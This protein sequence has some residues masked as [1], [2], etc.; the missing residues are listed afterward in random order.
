M[1]IEELRRIIENSDFEVFGLRAD[2]Y[3]YSIGDDAHVSH[4]LFQDP[5]WDE[6][7]NLIYQE[8]EG[9]YK[10]FFDAGELDGTCAIE[11]N[12]YDSDEK[13]ARKLNILSNYGKYFYLIGG[14]DSSYGNDE[15]EIIIEDAKII[16]ILN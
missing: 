1:T 7:G 3:K 15:D 11:I 2:D 5:D 6:Y 14:D 13:I 12:D 10:G 8:G 16:A 4:Q 9:F